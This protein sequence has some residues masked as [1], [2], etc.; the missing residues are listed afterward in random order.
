[1]FGEGKIKK[2]S[3]CTYRSFDKFWLIKYLA[4]LADGPAVYVR[5]RG[6]G[7]CYLTS[8]DWTKTL[9]LLQVTNS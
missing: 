8:T 6:Q 3:P 2:I 5:W 4:E 9:S 1:M 7:I